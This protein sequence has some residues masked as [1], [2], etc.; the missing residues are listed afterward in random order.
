MFP[1]STFGSDKHTHIHR[2]KER[3]GKKLTH[4]VNEFRYEKVSE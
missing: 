4:H 1:L 2:E 3:R